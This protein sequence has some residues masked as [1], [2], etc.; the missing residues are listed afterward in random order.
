MRKTHLLCW[1]SLS[2]FFMATIPCSCS[3]KHPA[4]S[5][6]K[7]I[8]DPE[9]AVAIDAEDDKFYEMPADHTAYSPEMCIMCH[10]LKRLSE[11][12]LG[13]QDDECLDCHKLAH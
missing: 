2:M 11:S 10:H 1:L 12:H 8:V 4:P 9:D 5:A 3:S 13:V 6:H 7:A